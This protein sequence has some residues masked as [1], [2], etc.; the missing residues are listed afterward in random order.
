MLIGQFFADQT[1]LYHQSSGLRHNPLNLRGY[2]GRAFFQL[3]ALPRH[4]F[5]PRHEQAALAFDLFG[6][7]GP[8]G[9]Q[10]CQ[11]AAENRHVF[12]VPLGFKPGAAGAHLEQLAFDNGQFGLQQTAIQ[13]NQQIANFYRL[14]FD[15]RNF[16][17]NTAIRVLNNLTVLFHFQ[18]TR[19]H[20]SAVDIGKHAPPAKT[21]HQ[22]CKRN[23]A[24]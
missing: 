13:L 15:H 17:H 23:H 24:G 18:L 14:T 11:F 5:A 4:A 19:R 8:G 6:H 16:G 22:R 2:L 21:E 20:D 9:G 12:I 10:F 3:F 7:F 1:Q